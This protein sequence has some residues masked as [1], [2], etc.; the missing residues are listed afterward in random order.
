M[1]D[2]DPGDL[3]WKVWDNEL[4]ERVAA[5][6]HLPASRVA[7]LEDQQPSWLEE[8]LGGLAIAG[9]H[10]EEVTIFRRVATAIRALAELGRVVIVG[11]GAVFVT[12]DMPAGVHLRLVAPVGFRVASTAAAKGVSPDEAGR[13]GARYGPLPRVVLSPAL[14]PPPAVAGGVHDDAEHGGL[15]RLPT[16]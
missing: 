9:N 13:V 14:A 16:S 3:P 8:A 1:N 6:H 5:E 15:V 7:E 12:G 2:I 11:R 4:V 10:P